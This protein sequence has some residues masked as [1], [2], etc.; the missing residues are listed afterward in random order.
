MY[1]KQ[2]EK[3]RVLLV[4]LPLHSAVQPMKAQI[5]WVKWYPAVLCLLMS[6]SMVE[7]QYDLSS[8]FTSVSVYLSHILITTTQCTRMW[9]LKCSSSIYLYAEKAVSSSSTVEDEKRIL[10]P[11]NIN[12]EIMYPSLCVQKCSQILVMAYNNS[13]RVY[14]KL[15]TLTT[16]PSLTTSISRRE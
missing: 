5:S 11:R 4:L 10:P 7:L 13:T 9:S 6:S 16:V 14:K 2:K 3:C 8:W 1:R 12:H 15:Y